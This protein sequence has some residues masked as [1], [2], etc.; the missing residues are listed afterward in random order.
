MRF[1]IDHDLHMHSQLSDCSS[2]PLQTPQALLEYAEENHLSTLCLTDHYWDSLVPGASW[3]YQPQNYDHIAKSLPLP[4]SDKVRFLFGCETDMDK[5]GTIGVPRERFDDFDFIIVPL[6]HLHMDT[7]TH[8]LPHDDVPARARHLMKRMEQ[9]LAADLPFGKV[10]IAHFTC[11]L[12][13]HD[14]K[15]YLQVLDMIPD[16]AYARFFRACAEKGC[17]I[18]LNMELKELKDEQ[19][20]PTILRPYQIAKDAGCKFYLG[21]DTHHPRDSEGAMERF[22]LMVDLL[23]LTEDDKFRLPTEP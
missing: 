7:F 2:D 1:V 6:S 18:E 16:E 22:N 13:M 9:F 20:L 19:I 14:E 23:E 8:D 10:G 17:G 21:S 3:W 12:I 11:S 5:F 15:R 4:K